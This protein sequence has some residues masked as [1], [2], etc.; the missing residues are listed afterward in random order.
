MGNNLTFEP[1]KCPYCKENIGKMKI[2]NREKHKRECAEKHA[3]IIDH[4]FILHKGW[5]KTRNH[6]RVCDD[7]VNK[8]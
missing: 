8:Q 1:L 3:R 4:Q 7:K 6:G 2:H 5:V